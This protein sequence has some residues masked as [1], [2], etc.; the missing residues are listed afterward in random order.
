MPYDAGMPLRLLEDVRY[1]LRL[2]AKSPGFTALALLT[3]ALGIGANTAIFSILDPLLL[4]KLPVR[5]PDELVWVNSTGTLG[6]AEISEVETYDAYREKASVLSSVLAFSRVAPYEVTHDG[7]MTSAKGELVSGNYF[8]SMGV[9]PIAGRVFTHAEER[10]PGTLVL[11]F[12]FWKREFN[13]DP[14]AVGQ[15]L[16]FGDQADASRA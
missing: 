2:L 7:R 13:S 8:E 3:L 12:D 15:V 5:N 16:T 9:R 11:S 4:R 14:L 1:G 10:G 6:P